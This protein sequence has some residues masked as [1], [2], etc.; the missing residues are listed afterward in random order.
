FQERARTK[1]INCRVRPE[2]ARL[3]RR[4]CRSRESPSRGGTTGEGQPSL[5]HHDRVSGPHLRSRRLPSATSYP[6]RTVAPCPKVGPGATV[7]DIGY[8]VS[9]ILPRMP[10]I[11]DTGYP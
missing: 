1:G 10:A 9:L 11:R 5:G 2:A 6:A 8:G 7:G 4:T 3:P